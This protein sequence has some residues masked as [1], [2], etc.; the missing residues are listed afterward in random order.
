MVILLGKHVLLQF[1]QTG[2]VL[3]QVRMIKITTYLLIL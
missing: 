3:L 1:W 2:R